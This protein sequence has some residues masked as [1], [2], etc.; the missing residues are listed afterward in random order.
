MSSAFVRR[1][2]FFGGSGRP[3]SPSSI[4][5]SPSV[6]SAAGSSSRIGLRLRRFE[7]A[8]LAWSI[9]FV[10]SAE[11]SVGMPYLAASAGLTIQGEVAAVASRSRQSRRK[12]FKM[13]FEKASRSR[14][15]RARKVSQSNGKGLIGGK[16]A[17]ATNLSCSARTS[18]QL[19]PSPE[20]A[21]PSL[22]TTRP[23]TSTSWTEYVYLSGGSRRSA[24]SWLRRRS[25]PT[26]CG[27]FGDGGGESESVLLVLGLPGLTGENWTGV[28][29]RAG[30]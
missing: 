5:L 23:L 2:R 21:S 19:V 28:V 18:I 25:E 7:A 4:L 30:G 27:P 12:R 24:S 13:D 17:G 11:S 14:L 1:L 20:P 22:P 6:S 16:E 8:S 26:T 10:S 9:S 3:S 29:A 15:Q